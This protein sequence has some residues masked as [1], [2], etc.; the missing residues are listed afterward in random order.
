MP[1]FFG[2]PRGRR[3]GIRSGASEL[4]GCLGLKIGNFGCS[5]GCAIIFI[6]VAIAATIAVLLMKFYFHLF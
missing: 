6:L 4:E 5:F 1:G 3:D 2:R